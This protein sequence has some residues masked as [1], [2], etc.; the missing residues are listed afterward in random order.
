MICCQFNQLK[1][2]KTAF[3]AWKII[4]AAV[5]TLAFKPIK[6]SCSGLQRSMQWRV[7]KH[8]HRMTQTLTY[9]DTS[10]FRYIMIYLYYSI[11]I[12][13]TWFPI[14]ISIWGSLIFSLGKAR[15]DECNIGILI[16]DRIWRYLSNI[17]SKIFQASHLS[18]FIQEG[19]PIITN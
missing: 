15:L 16:G 2:S 4:F 8:R 11:F 18:S 5:P 10:R 3:T 17:Y 1:T 14:N 6:V 9:T 19:I 13:E 12:S 7:L